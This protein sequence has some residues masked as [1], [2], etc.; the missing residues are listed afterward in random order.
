L[1]WINEFSTQL[2]FAGI[3]SLSAL[4]IML[5]FWTSR[6]G[7]SKDDRKP[8]GSMSVLQYLQTEIK[9][10]LES[11]R[12]KHDELAITVAALPNRSEIQQKLTQI[13]SRIDT[14]QD[15]SPTSQ[16]GEL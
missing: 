8:N 16:Q 3:F 2:G 1:E 5:K 11:L 7:G 6:N 10:D 4:Y 13:H 9:P 15:K 12:D 14:K